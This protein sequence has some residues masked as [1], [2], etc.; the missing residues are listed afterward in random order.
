MVFAGAVLLWVVGRA[1]ERS[2]PRIGVAGIGMAVY[3][4][5]AA[6]SL[7][8][9]DPRPER[10]G[11]KLI[12]LAMLVGLCVV[13]ADLVPR[14]GFPAVARTVL[15][16]TLVTSVLALIGVGLFYAGVRSPF[17]GTYGDLTPGAYAR[18]QAALPHPNLL[19]SFCVFAYGC[20]T[21][22]DAGLSRGWRR[23]AI[24]AVTL[25]SLSTFSRGILALAIAALVRH[26]LTPGR[27]FFAVIIAVL[28]G[29][30]MAFLSWTNLALDPTRPWEA[31]FLETPSPRRQGIVSSLATLR[32]HPLLGIGPGG[33][34][35]TSQG[36]PFDA[37][38]TVLNVAASLGLPALAG[39]LLI[40]WGRW[41]ERARPTDRATWGM[42]AGFAL[43]SLGHDIEDFRH[44]WVAF[45]LAAVGRAAGPAAVDPRAT[46][47]H[48]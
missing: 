10:G 4:G 45:G 26:A 5:M 8:L 15:L 43:E 7:L 22:A 18:A 32:A 19:A 33:T 38:C 47:P 46:L 25:T 3:L 6:L 37:H 17:V 20:V 34:T 44:V 36:A 23:L 42:L 11:A 9:A 2:W 1:R 30:F 14:I 16:T 27:R 21:R 24:M 31:R 13:T 41:H 40:P 28:F 39:L 48:R 12:G 35:G 29:L